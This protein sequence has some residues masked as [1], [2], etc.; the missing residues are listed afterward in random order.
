MDKWYIIIVE[1]CNCNNLI[2]L[3]TLGYQLR[4]ANTLLLRLISRI[5]FMY[6]IITLK[7]KL[8]VQNNDNK[9]NKESNNSVNKN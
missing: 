5:Q 6:I 9:Q 4:V 1:I 3:C 8:K 7:I 2:K